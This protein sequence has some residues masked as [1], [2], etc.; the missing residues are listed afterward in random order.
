MR[1]VMLG[2]MLAVLF[3]MQ[4]AEAGWTPIDAPGASMT[5]SYGIDGGN[6]VGQYFGWSGSHGFLYDGTNWTNL[7]FP[8]AADTAPID[9]EGGTI[10][11]TLD[12]QTTPHGF[13]FD[14]TTW[15][16][17]DFPGAPETYVFAIDGGYI[18]GCYGSSGA[19]HGFLY[20][21]INWTTLDAP[22]A[23]MTYAQGIDIDRG[24]RGTIVGYGGAAPDYGWL[25]DIDTKVF[26]PFYG[27]G[28]GRA[29]PFDIEGNNIIGHYYE[30]GGGRYGFLYDGTNWTTLDFPG[31]V[32]T[33]P[34]DIDGN[35]IVGYYDAPGSPGHGFI[36]TFDQASTPE[37]Q[38]EEILDFV[39]E[40]VGDGTLVGVGPGKSAENR[41]VAVMNML[42]DAWVWIEGGSYHQACH[43]LQ[44]VL[45][46]CDGQKFPADTVEGD[47]AA[48]LSDRISDLMDDMCEDTMFAP[49]EVMTWVPPYVAKSSLME[50]K[51][52]FGTCGPKDGLTR[53][54]LQFWVPRADG[55]IKYADHEWYTPTDADVDAWRSW[56]HSNGIKC[57]LCIYNNIGAWDWNLAR[58]AFRDKQQDFINAL[59][60][61]MDRLEL[62]GIDIDLEGLD[63][64]ILP[65][66]RH[67]FQQFILNLSIA[68]HDFGDKIL[69]VDTFSQTYNAPNIDWWPDWV[70]AVDNIHSMGY[71]TEGD[72]DLCEGGID[73]QK[74]STQQAIGYLSGYDMDDVLMGMPAFKSSWGI[75]SGRGTSAQEHVQE[76][77]YDLPEPTGIAIWSLQHLLESEAPVGSPW[78]TSDLWCE[79]KE[80]KGDD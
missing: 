48:E 27:P 70:W 33:Y 15:R 29:F 4:Y 55:T 64:A 57:L 9:I 38:I 40:S 39:Y 6:I 22:G 3:T 47:A 43:Q 37:E 35:K 58:T 54:G 65:S 63:P 28:G 21:G 2:A 23:S 51:K 7:D 62:D 76:I 11:G 79:I 74:Y 24:T 61:E 25:Y 5:Y 41:L 17:I 80:L 56:C 77:H 19:Y 34:F 13:Q 31:A 8:G 12:G 10:V 42:E 59:V 71:D 75:S 67:A 14:G 60:C 18:V 73:L 16:T 46:K 26:T 1:N 69:T 44:D 32:G 36:Y 66:D 72:N 53:V 45:K 20:D 52:D 50:V 78:R 68:V 30:V 49:A